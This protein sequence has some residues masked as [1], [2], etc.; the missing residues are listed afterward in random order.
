MNSDRFFM[1]VIGIMSAAFLTLAA[2]VSL[3]YFL[4]PAP[5][6]EGATRGSFWCEGEA[7]REESGLPNEWRR[8]CEHLLWELEQGRRNSVSETCL[9]GF[10]SGLIYESR[11]HEGQV[12]YR[13]IDPPPEY[14]RWRRAGSPDGGWDGGW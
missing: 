1:A 12:P 2:G 4:T 11:E 3:F 7:T 6:W 8:C 13:W 5:P 10:E 9:D 14:K